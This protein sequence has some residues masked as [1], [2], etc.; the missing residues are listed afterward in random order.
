MDERA[1]RAGLP[2]ARS[3]RSLRGASR[4]SSRIPRSTNSSSNQVGRLPVW[5]LG[6]KWL[7]QWIGKSNW[8]HLTP[9]T[10]HRLLWLLLVVPIH[11][12]QSGR[13]LVS[14]HTPA[15][16]VLE[17]RRGPRSARNRVRIDPLPVGRRGDN[18]A[19][20]GRRHHRPGA[21]GRGARA[22]PRPL[23]QRPLRR[24]G[25]RRR[26]AAV[27]LDR[28]TRHRRLVR[29]RGQRRLRGR[30]AL[31]EGRVL[32]DRP[33]GRGAL[34]RPRGDRRGRHDGYGYPLVAEHQVQPEQLAGRA[35][36]PAGKREHGKA[37]DRD[38]PA[39]HAL[40]RR[41]P[42][43]VEE[44][45]AAAGGIHHGRRR[46]Q[47]HARRAPAP[48]RLHLRS[49]L[50]SGGRVD[51]ARAVV[52]QAGLR[53]RGE[54]PE[55]P[56]RGAGSFRLLRRGRGRLEAE[57]HRHGSGGERCGAADHEHQ[58]GSGRGGRGRVTSHAFDGRTS[59][60]RQPLRRGHEA[61]ARAAVALQL[62]RLQ[63]A[64]QAAHGRGGPRFAAARAGQSP[65]RRFVR[66]GLRDHLREPGT[67]SAATSPSCSG[68]PTRQASS[69]MPSRPTTSTC[70]RP[71]PRPATRPPSTPGTW[72]VASTP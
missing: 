21:C 4:R 71:T 26:T 20:R 47:R 16:R 22:G 12:D 59:A 62:L 69:T 5:C 46:A 35:R 45:W 50:P 1:G 18:P 58:R 68:R 43:P 36:D 32:L 14:Q 41:V 70:S 19:R 49:R 53:L 51:V 30:I 6:G 17:Q 8:P 55:L 29:P 15:G 25:V 24:H 28:A 54:L 66:G 11:P 67:T 42:G 34:E 10:P 61:L 13:E 57:P 3:S 38:V 31:R 44:P 64:L 33:E 65:G 27:R 72:T 56:Q 39:Q 23:R 2:R 63:L 52:Q 9:L 7:A 37:G 40:R 60:T 48:E